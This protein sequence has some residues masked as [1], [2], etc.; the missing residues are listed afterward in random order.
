MA[1]LTVSMIISDTLTL[2]APGRL[3]TFWA[4]LRGLSG[5]A[6]PPGGLAP[7]QCCILG[8]VAGGADVHFGH[9]E[10]DSSSVF[11]GNLQLVHFCNF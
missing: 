11:F 1:F 3:P 7:T 9:I 4:A 6:P 10:G 8:L 5:R 2:G